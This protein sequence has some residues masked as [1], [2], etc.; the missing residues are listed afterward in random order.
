M[1]VAFIAIFLP[2]SVIFRG[3]GIPAVR[4][5][6][7][8]D[9]RELGGMLHG[10]VRKSLRVMGRFQRLELDNRDSLCGF[11]RPHAAVRI[12]LG[13]RTFQEILKLLFTEEDQSVSMW[14]L[15]IRRLVSV[16][17]TF[18]VKSEEDKR[19]VPLVL[20]SQSLPTGAMH[21]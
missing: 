15:Q 20:G 14:A 8:L 19:L 11:Q 12:S 7:I 3:A 16:A 13:A 5:V 6:V 18:H 2:E 10:V 4:C 17:T 9:A 21:P 1:V